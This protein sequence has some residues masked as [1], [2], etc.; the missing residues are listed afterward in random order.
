MNIVI[1][2]G[3]TR[4]YLD[5]VRFIS[6]ASSGRM[7]HAIAQAAARA[8]HRVTLVSGPV[9]L[10]DPPGVKVVRVVSARDMYEAVR[11]AFARADCL[12]GA[13]A[14]ADLRPT[15]R[16]RG[17][18]KKSDVPSS[19]ALKPTVDILATLGKRKGRRLIIGFA[20]EVRKPITRALEKMRRKNA[21]AIVVNG[22]AAMG[23]ER[24]SAIVL[25][26]SGDRIEIRNAP[27][28]RIGRLLVR[29]VEELRGG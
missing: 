26:P 28:P 24:S 12:I 1:T 6:N 17:K 5:D 20:L 3:P 25:F 8:G 2:A 13:A 18:A 11:K 4:E 14:P 19:L 9:V 21:D 27:K 23:A 22:P 16:I 7:G 15:R 10:P 29:I